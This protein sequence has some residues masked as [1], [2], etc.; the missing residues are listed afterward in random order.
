MSVLNL[1]IM[2]TNISD[3]WLNQHSLVLKTLPKI[4]ARV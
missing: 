1:S 3:A 2:D 4:D